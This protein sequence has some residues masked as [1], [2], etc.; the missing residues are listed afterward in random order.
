ML[1]M[2]FAEDIESILAETPSSR[3]TLLFSATLPKR[4]AAIARRHLH[5]PV[6]ISIGDEVRSRDGR[7]GS[8]TAP[9]S[10][11]EAH[12]AAA[13]GRML[14]VESPAAAIVFCRT[15]EAVDGLTETL[16]GR[17]YRAEA[18]HGGMT[19]EQRNRV[20]E[21]LRG[22]AADLLIATD[23]AARGLDI[24]HLSHVVNYDVPCEVESYVH[25][26]GR[27]GPRRTGGRRHHAG[28]A[29]RAPE[30]ARRSSGRPS[31]RSPSRRSP[32]WPTFGRAGST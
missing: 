22:G 1:D 9:T 3:Q 18:L 15:R 32:R 17:G 19:Q 29:A 2:G 7:L 24:E 13:L 4:I 20:M 30:A 10:C 5:D 27:V 28:R 14:D 16:N 12:K 23:V 21:R 31:R 26:I 11:S 25:R 8:G 6:R